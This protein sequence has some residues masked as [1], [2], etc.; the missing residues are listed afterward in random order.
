MIRI[1]QYSLTDF[2]N[3]YLPAQ[4]PR[5][6]IKATFL[7]HTWRPRREDYHGAGTIEG[8]RDYH[9]NSRGWSDIGT[10]AYAAPDGTVYNGRPLSWSNYCHALRKKPWADC[11]ADYRE[12]AT[13]ATSWPN[14]YA[15]GIETIGNFDDEDPA[16]SLAMNT[17]LAVLAAVHRLYNLPPERLFL[18]RDVAYKTC[19]GSRVT[20]AWARAEVARRLGQAHDLRVILLPEETEIECNPAL[21][22]NTTR[23]DLRGV[24][25][26]VGYVVSTERFNTD[27]I[28]YVT[29]AKP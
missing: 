14:H 28:I 21:E 13:T 2:V 5:R 12:I 19:P 25:E 3:E 26:G 10:N 18:H 7:H 24:L 4:R 6:S 27:R 1:R 23:C 8:I 11:P 20:R 29:E 17:A 9:V 16:A 15:F 22:G